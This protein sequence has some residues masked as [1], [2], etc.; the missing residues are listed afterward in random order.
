MTW[1]IP[2]SCNSLWRNC[3]PDRTSETHGCDRLLERL[4]QLPSFDNRA[5]IE[6]S[7]CVEERSFLYWERPE[8]AEPF[9]GIFGQST[10]HLHGRLKR[11]VSI[12][13]RV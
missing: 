7:S 10:N 8:A 2:R 4:R 5:V 3:T 11:S 1:S 13:A 12:T 6:A 9:Y